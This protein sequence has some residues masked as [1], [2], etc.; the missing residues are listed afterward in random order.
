MVDDGL[1]VGGGVNV[2]GGA[3]VVGALLREEREG[4]DLEW[5]GLVVG[6]VDVQHVELGRR[7]GVND[8]L[9]RAE[10]IEVPR[11]V[12]HEAAP[13]V[14]GSVANLH[15]AVHELEAA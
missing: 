1:N 4:G 10:R 12:D 15:R 8:V 2:G 11:R 14:H 9:D 5:E 13:R 6:E 7:H 3:R